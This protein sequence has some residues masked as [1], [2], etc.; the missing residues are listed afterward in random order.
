VVVVE[1]AVLVVVAALVTGGLVAFVVG[2]E[3][4]VVAVLPLSSTD[5]RGPPFHDARTSMRPSSDVNVAPADGPDEVSLTDQPVPGTAPTRLAE[6]GQKRT[7]TVPPAVLRGSVVHGGAVVGEVA[8]GSGLEA[9]VTGLADAGGVSA[10]TGDV[11][12]A[13]T[14]VVADAVEGATV[15][16]VDRRSRTTVGLSASAGAA[17]R[18]WP[19]EFTPTAAT[20]VAATVA[21]TQS[22]TKSTRRRTNPWC[23]ID[24]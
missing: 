4:G 20:A 7:V 2:A 9:D 15:V 10:S 19:I 11:V 8:A 21:L 17:S 18:R 12:V 22:S 23:G 24:G 13:A 6:P 14:V 16:T 1:A 3:A 5:Q